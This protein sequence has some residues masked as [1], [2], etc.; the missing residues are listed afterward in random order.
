MAIKHSKVN[1]WVVMPVYNEDHSIKKVVEEWLDA[2]R[3]HC[4]NFVLCLINDGSTDHSRK[5]IQSMAHLNPEIMVI[6]KENSGHGQSCLSGYREAIEHGAV[7]REA[8]APYGGTLVAQERLDAYLCGDDT[9]LRFRSL[10]LDEAG[11]LLGIASED[12]GSTQASD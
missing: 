9:A 5:L 4:A 12:T 10:G 6:D 11:V 2:L 3:T 1:L 7:V 8:A